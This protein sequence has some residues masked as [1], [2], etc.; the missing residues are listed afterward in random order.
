MH[1][2]TTSRMRPGSANSNAWQKG[3]ALSRFGIQRPE[4]A[5]RLHSNRWDLLLQVFF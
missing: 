4:V 3:G 1:R 5:L 2:T